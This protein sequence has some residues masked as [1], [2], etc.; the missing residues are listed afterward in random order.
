MYTQYDLTFKY[1]HDYDLDNKTRE[2][3]LQSRIESRFCIVGRPSHEFIIIAFY[4][5]GA[6]LVAVTVVTD[7]E[8]INQV[9]I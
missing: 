8:T 9:S 5:A 7:R 2:H 3:L 1:S 4:D 6:E